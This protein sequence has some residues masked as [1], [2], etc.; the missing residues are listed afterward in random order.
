MVL[1][2]SESSNDPAAR[3]EMAPAPVTRKRRR[4]GTGAR[5][6]SN[7]GRIS[8]KLRPEILPAR[9]PHRI[10]PNRIARPPN[11]ASGSREP[12]TRFRHQPRSRGDGGGIW[13]ESFLI[14]AGS[15]SKNRLV[16]DYTRTTKGGATEAREKDD[17]GGKRWNFCTREENEKNRKGKGRETRVNHTTRGA[18][19]LPRSSATARGPTQHRA[20]CR[21]RGENGTRAGCAE[22]RGWERRKGRGG[23]DGPRR[24]G[25]YRRS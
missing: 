4:R 17:D 3:V 1:D 12:S 9:L 23:S 19:R 2:R 18:R 13:S 24:G 16:L 25:H 7:S 14:G 20:S 21:R 15:V 6:R 11:W 22:H 10:A 8:K 5:T